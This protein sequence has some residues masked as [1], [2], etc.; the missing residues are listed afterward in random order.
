MPKLRPEIQAQRAQERIAQIRAEL[1]EID[2]Y[3]SSGTLLE[4]M[5][6]CGKPTCRCAQEPAARHGPYYEWGHMKGGKLVH[7]L[8]SVTQAEI[9]K[10]AIANYRKVKKLMHAWETETERLIDAEPPRQ[11]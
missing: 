8:V 9:L 4:R 2:T 1:A 6:T 11:P 10:I 3:L 5:K 7:R